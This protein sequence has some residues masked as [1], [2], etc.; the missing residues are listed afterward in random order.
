[1]LAARLGHGVGPDLGALTMAELWG[2][3]LFLRALAEKGG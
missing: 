3:Y 1:M 2:V